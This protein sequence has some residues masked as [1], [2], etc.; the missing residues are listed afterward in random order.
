M[1]PWIDY[2]IVG[3][4]PYGLSLGAH[5]AARGADF[6]IFG[7]PMAVWRSHMP[8]GMYLKSEGFA[9]DIFD[10]RGQHTL[11]DFCERHGYAYADVGVPIPVEVFY[12]YGRE[13]QERLLPDLDTRHIAGI[14]SET[15]GFL[16]RLDDGQA[17]RAR[18]VIVAVG[19]AH[20]AFVPHELQALPPQFVSHTSQQRSM[21][22]FSGKKVLVLGA[23]SSAVDTAGLLHQA[24]ADTEIATRRPKIWFNHPPDNK[25]GLELA[26]AR[27]LKPR[28]GLGLGWRS[29]MASDL[30]T[31]FHGMPERFRLRV[32]RGHLGPSAGW[33]SRQMVE[34]KVPIRTDMTLR[35]AAVKGDRVVVT[36][37][38][39][40]G[41]QEQVVVDHL[42]AG[43]GYK[44]DLDRLEFLDEP[45]RAQISRVHN[46]PRLSRFFESS[47]PN[48]YFVGPSA[49]NSFGP[50]LRFA[51]GAKF[52]SRH[53]SRHLTR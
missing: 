48:L 21:T 6:R 9:S 51:W 19:I 30:P 26:Y 18:R 3:A 45:M 33:V 47:V 4:G 50:L 40:D 13:F 52:T 39:P 53:L 23:G 24:G 44:V 8:S 2:A 28:S 22:D 38:K 36:F 5:L 34:G 35:Q 49:A 25:R 12:A 46:T 14:T 41:A 37:D 27:L 29:R 32:T 11:R 1:T 20:Y 42:V 17:V 43:T 31:I 15:G 7:S 16:L 10:P